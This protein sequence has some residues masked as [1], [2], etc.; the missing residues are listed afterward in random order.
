MLCPN[1]EDAFLEG[2]I[3]RLMTSHAAQQGCRQF[4]S[5]QPP[6]TPSNAVGECSHHYLNLKP[7]PNGSFVAHDNALWLGTVGI[8]NDT[9]EH[10]L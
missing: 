5:G 10:L 4:N 1:S 6:K 3:C 2:C 8:V 9:A 7:V